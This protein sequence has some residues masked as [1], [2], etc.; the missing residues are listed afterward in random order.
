[1]KASTPLIPVAADEIAASLPK[2]GDRLAVLPEIVV[3]VGKPSG[4]HDVD[5][6]VTKLE[7][8]PSFPKTGGRLVESPRIV[9]GVGKPSGPQIVVVTAMVP[10]LAERGMMGVGRPSVP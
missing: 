7:I 4:P 3:G 2:T 6:I 5:V 10:K 8:A 9:V 1:M